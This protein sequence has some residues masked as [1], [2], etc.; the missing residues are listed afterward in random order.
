MPR[1]SFSF[2]SFILKFGVLTVIL[3]LVFIGLVGFFF[4]P[5][6]INN[7]NR[8]EFKIS[9]GEGADQ[10]SARL[11]SSGL[12]RSKEAFKLYLLASGVSNKI[13]AGFFYLSP[14][15]SL[16]SLASSLTSAQTKQVWVTIPEGLRRQE[17]ANLIL[18]ALEK[19]DMPHKFDPE[20]FISLTQDLEGRLYPDTYA[21][22]ENTDAQTVID[23]LTK[24]FN[25]VMDSLNFD[26]KDFD[27]II[28]LASLIE[29]EAAFDSERSEIAGILIN[30]LNSNWPLQIDASVQFALANSVCRLRI[31]DWW[32]KSLTRDDLKFNSPYNTY[33]N[34]GLPPGP[35]S[36]PGKASLEAAA[37][38]TKT[39]NWFY[40]H[41]SKGQIHFARSVK[42]HNQNVCTYLKKDC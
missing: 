24:Q 6:D 38:P 10:I 34:P 27:Q 17:I 3:I 18:D 5:A 41:D 33:N 29:R 4:Q 23:R 9:S 15:Q 31:C 13:Q 40:L 37:H 30:R 35:I 19:E 8:L 25:Q 1:K 21:F 2:I 42:E 36:S 28:I 16:S 7:Q 22:S 39:D 26:P 20:Q 11:Q 32:P 14:S 12:I